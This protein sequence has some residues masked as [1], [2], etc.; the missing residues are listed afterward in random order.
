MPPAL[1]RQVFLPTGWRP[2][3]HRQPPHRRGVFCL[4][5]SVG[6]LLLI[7]WA[8]QSRHPQSAHAL[9]SVGVVLALV[10]STLLL[11]GRQGIMSVQQYAGEEGA[12]V[13]LKFMRRVLARARTKFLGFEDL[14]M[15]MKNLSVL[16]NQSVRTA[17]AGQSENFESL[18]AYVLQCHCVLRSLC[19]GADRTGGLEYVRQH[20]PHV[21]RPPP[22]PVRHQDRAGV[23]QGHHVHHHRGVHAPRLRAGKGAQELHPDDRL[24]CRHRVVLPRHRKGVHGHRRL[25]A[26][27]QEV[28]LLREPGEFLRAGA[29]P[30]A[31]ALVVGAL[32]G[33]LRVHREPQT[34]LPVGLHE[35]QNQVSR[36]PGGLH[37][38]PS[39]RTG[40]ARALP[41]RHAL[42]ADEPRRRVCHLPDAHDLR[43]HHAL[44]TL[45]PRG[46]LAAVSQ[47]KQQVSHLPVP[48]F[49]ILRYSILASKLLISDASPVFLCSVLLFIGFL[50]P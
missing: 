37:Q 41:R 5:V 15:K 38:A 48:F 32:D 14:Y 4:S 6:V 16:V 39:A 7:P 29:H 2:L 9:A 42:G 27:E 23:D 11:Y 46:L 22:G 20:R 35:H 49:V 47:G 3:R 17:D 19:Q 8:S 34:R 50:S 26:G 44:P 25:V 30:P 10:T 40:G 28:R 1:T 12:P 43:A 21:E 45:L 31:A 33:A 13:G 36:T 18:H 24:P